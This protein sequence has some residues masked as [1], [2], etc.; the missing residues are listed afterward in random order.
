MKIYAR[1]IPP[2]YQESPLFL[3]AEFF[4]DDIAVYGNRDYKEHIP[5]VFE[6]IRGALE[7]GSS[8][9]PGKI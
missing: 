1:Q 8:W 9:I 7:T 6:R 2:E 5:A 3:G 4:P